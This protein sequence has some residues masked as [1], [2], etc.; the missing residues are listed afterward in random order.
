MLSIFD[1]GGFS[2]CPAPFNLAAH[3]LAAGQGQPEKEA[4]LV[5]GQ[6]SV[7][8]W[9]YGQIMQAVLWIATGLVQNGLRSGDYVLL[10]LGNTVDFTLSYLGALA[11]GMVPVPTS[12]A[13]TVRETQVIVDMLHP[14]CVL[15]DEHISCPA[16]ASFVSLEELR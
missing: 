6:G 2:P 7:E 9:T 12:S 16:H 14:S 10:R 8:S 15:H 11:A 3:V 1:E 13:L 4:L 5:L